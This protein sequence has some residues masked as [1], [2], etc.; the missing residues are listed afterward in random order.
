ME[1]VYLRIPLQVRLID[2]LLATLNLVKVLI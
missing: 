2:L 1:L